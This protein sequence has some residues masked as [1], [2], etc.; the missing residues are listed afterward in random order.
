MYNKKKHHGSGQVKPHYHRDEGGSA[1]APSENPGQKPVNP[2]RSGSQDSA[3][4]KPGS[5]NNPPRPPAEGNRP[6][7]G[8]NNANEA[9]L[10]RREQ[11][12][13]NYW[14]NRRKKN[15]PQSGGERTGQQPQSPQSGNIQNRA[16]RQPEPRPE[17][18]R[19]PVVLP[20][21]IQTLEP[22][23][24]S[25]LEFKPA[26]SGE[27]TEAKVICPICEQVIQHLSTAIWHKEHAIPAHFDCVLKE[28]VQTYQEQLGKHRRIYYIGKGQF[29]IVKETFDKRG[30]LKSYQ[31]IER[32]PYEHSEA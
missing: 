24:D 12:N 23:Q 11:K 6:R 2:P 27:E 17:P 19:E 29:A 8:D 4:R 25:I 18:P 15:R 1:P 28:L 32:I 7:P 22:L 14:R 10:S 13:R 30:Q 5:Q 20:D 9:G 16:P 26:V 21:D 3:D 31:I